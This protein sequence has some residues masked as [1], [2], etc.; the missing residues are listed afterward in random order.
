MFALLK[1]MFSRFCIVVLTKVPLLKNRV[2]DV[3][4]QTPFS[5]GGPY[6]YNSE[7]LELFPYKNP[8]Y[9]VILHVQFCVLVVFPERS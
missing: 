4:I 2:A 3:S 9:G 5:Q 7:L 6:I 8:S 1:V